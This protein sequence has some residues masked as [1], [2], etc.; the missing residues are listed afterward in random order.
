MAFVV[1]ITGLP[2]SGKTTISRHLLELFKRADVD[3]EYLR[4][5]AFRK[6]IAP[7]PRYDEHE[8][9]RVYK[10]LAKL[11]KRK[12]A[13]GENVL[14]DATAHRKTFRY[15]TRRAVKNF[16][17]VYVK[18]GLEACIERESKR[19]GG[20]VATNLYK[21]ALKRKRS[22]G[23][24]DLDLGTKEGPGKQGEGIGEVVGVDVPYEE[25]SPEII[26]DSETSAPEESA[27]TIFEY[28]EERRMF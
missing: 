19:R 15:E 14:V 4:L 21:K 28:L 9:D 17:E 1:W 10:E 3:V 11:V 16:V 7:K 24:G 27:M 22:L 25:G 8:R 5:D 18:C 2:G 12:F 6:K 13:S 26:I 23:T 20:L